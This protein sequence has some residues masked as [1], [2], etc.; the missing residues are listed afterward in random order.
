M[1]AIVSEIGEIILE[2]T[3][4]IAVLGMFIAALLVATAF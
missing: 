4:G 1:E 3:A 2:S